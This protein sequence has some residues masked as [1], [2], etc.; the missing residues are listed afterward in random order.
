MDRKME[1]RLSDEY[2]RY[3]GSQMFHVTPQPL[4]PGF[5]S[6]R[7]G[8]AMP[9]R[10]GRARENLKNTLLYNLCDELDKLGRP[11]TSEERLSHLDAV[12]RVRHRHRRPLQVQAVREDELVD[13]P[14]E[15]EEDA[16]PAE[17]GEDA[18]PTA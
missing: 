12:H 16:V 5:R 2:D 7:L 11:M 17:D 18:L 9:M 1:E 4:L 3:G 10:T 13:P 14:V 8:S 15:D 6:R